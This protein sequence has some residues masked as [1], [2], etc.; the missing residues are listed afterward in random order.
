MLA[1]ITPFALL[2][3]SQIVLAGLMDFLPYGPADGAS[4]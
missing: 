1:L 4:R 3:E 2:I